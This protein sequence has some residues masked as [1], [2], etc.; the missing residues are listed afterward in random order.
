ENAVDLAFALMGLQDQFETDGFDQYKLNIL[1]ALVGAC[2][3]KVAPTLIEQYFFPHYS[4]AQRHTILIALA[5]GA[6]ELAGFPRPPPPP[7]SLTSSTPS[8][9]AL[10]AP[11]ED[12]F[13]SKRLP[14][15]LHRRLLASPSS[16]SAPP[17][18]PIPTKSL[19]P[20][21]LDQIT[22]ELTSAALSGAKTEAETTIPL[23][24]KEKLLTVRRFASA[25]KESTSIGNGNGNGNGTTSANFTQLAAEFFLGPL[26]NRF[27]EHLRQTA[28]QSKR[29]AYA[30][31]ANSAALLEPLVLSR[32]LGTLTVLLHASR[33]SPHFLAFLAPQSLE[34]LLALRTDSSEEVDSTVLACEMEVLLVVFDGVV[35]GDGGHA[36]MRSVQGGG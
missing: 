25:S 13:P 23:A 17:S 7:P 14:P 11:Q 5:L 34:L 12:L 32:Y 30:G 18:T 36:L 1:A 21:A 9:A 35:E 24:A 4:I 20:T 3:I 29:S 16:S 31:G 22:A 15:S 19:P 2:P 10:P 26:I 8:P 6:R 28:G 27:W 33:H